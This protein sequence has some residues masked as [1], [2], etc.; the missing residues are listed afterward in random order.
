[1][2]ALL[3]TLHQDTSTIQHLSREVVEG[4]IFFGDLLAGHFTLSLNS[5]DCLMWGIFLLNS[6]VTMLQTC[7]HSKYDT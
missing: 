7:L 6:R 2:W 4:N 1:M 3:P 5:K